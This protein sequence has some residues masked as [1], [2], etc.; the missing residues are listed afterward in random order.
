MW[1]SIPIRIRGCTGWR[2]R[3][4]LPTCTPLSKTRG[5]EKLRAHFAL[6]ELWYNAG[7]EALLR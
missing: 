1:Q 4:G 7:E 6:G 5:F 3:N 2:G